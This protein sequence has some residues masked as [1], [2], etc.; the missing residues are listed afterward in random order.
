M[1][2]LARLACRKCGHTVDVD[3]PWVRRHLPQLVDT[4]SNHLFSHLR[5]QSH[6]LVCSSCGAKSIS[7]TKPSAGAPRQSGVSGG[8]RGS[9][10]NLV[11]TVL[12]LRSWLYQSEMKLAQSLAAQTKSGKQLTARQRSA[13]KRLRDKALRRQVLPVFRG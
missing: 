8:S 7:I 9:D 4:P 6:R 12:G 11:A 3:V 13:L 10:A 2:I 5:A 1:A